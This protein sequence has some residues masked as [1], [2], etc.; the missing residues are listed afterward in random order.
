[1]N[2]NLIEKTVSVGL[3]LGTDQQA[4]DLMSGAQLGVGINPSKLDAATPLMFPPAVLVVTHVPSMWKDDPKT[5][6]MLKALIETHPT[7]V[8]GLDFNYT[9]ETAD[10]PLGHDGQVFH[11]PTQTKRSQPSPSFTFT[12]V[13]GNL[14]WNFFRQWVWDIQHPDTIASG[15]RFKELDPFMSSLYSMSMVAIQFDPTMRPENII[16]GMFYSNMF[17]TAPGGDF[18]IE[19]TVGTTKDIERSVEFVAH[20]QHNTATRDLAISIAKKLDLAKL[21]FNKLYPGQA[22]VATGLAD[23]GLEREVQ[24]FLSYPEA[25]A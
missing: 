9:L 4:A 11:T 12:E 24:D 13:T 25:T 14:I 7:S 2:N 3:G 6:Q 8:S 16:D 1:M 17:P 5:G 20:L 15:A 18:G 21:N 19:R 10:K 23:T 22:A